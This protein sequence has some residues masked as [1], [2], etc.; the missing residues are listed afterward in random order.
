MDSILPGSLDVSSTDNDEDDSN[1]SGPG[2]GSVAQATA[3]IWE[4]TIPIQ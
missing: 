1:G 4:T 2:A 3:L